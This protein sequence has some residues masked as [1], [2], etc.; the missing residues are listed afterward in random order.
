MKMFAFVY[1]DYFDAR[2]TNEFKQANYKQ[3]TKVHGTISKNCTFVGV[4]NNLIHIRY[5]IC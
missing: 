2:I 3:D 4:S 5:I 1:A